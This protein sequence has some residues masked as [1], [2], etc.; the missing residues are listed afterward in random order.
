MP[1]PSYVYVMRLN[2]GRVKIGYSNAPRLRA[3]QVNEDVPVKAILTQ[4][5]CRNRDKAYHLEQWVHARLSC[6]RW[7]G[8]YERFYMP[9]FTWRIVGVLVVVYRVLHFWK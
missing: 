1:K 8:K 4:Y 6:L 7:W 5:K 2:W 9:L 3:N